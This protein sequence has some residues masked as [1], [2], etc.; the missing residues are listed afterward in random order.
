MGNLCR[1]GFWVDQAADAIAHALVTLLADP[2]GAEAMGRRGRTLITNQYSWPQIA[3]SL[4][5]EYES[6]GSRAVRIA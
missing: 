4:I 1:T 5:N 6:L 2:S 3:A